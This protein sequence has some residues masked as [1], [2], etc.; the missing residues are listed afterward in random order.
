[1]KSTNSRSDEPSGESIDRFIELTRSTSTIPAAEKENA[2]E[3]KA[4]GERAHTSA[5]AG[6]QSE[7]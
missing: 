5:Q 7:D 2:R 3:R 6:D 4:V 1:M